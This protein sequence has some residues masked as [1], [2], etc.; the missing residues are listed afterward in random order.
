M[1][2]RIDTAAAIEWAREALARLD[3]AVTTAQIDAAQ[4]EYNLAHG[5]TVDGLY[6]D[7]PQ[8]ARRRWFA[9][10]GKGRTR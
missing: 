7:A 4:Q 10:G 8:P 3:Q 5:V 9:I 1:K 2:S 6:Q